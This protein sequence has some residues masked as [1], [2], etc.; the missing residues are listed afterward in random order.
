MGGVANTFFFVRNMII[1]IYTYFLEA[2]VAGSDCGFNY[3][4]SLEKTKYFYF[5]AVVTGGL[6]FYH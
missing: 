6:E 3:H 5:L 4:F 2:F 1:F